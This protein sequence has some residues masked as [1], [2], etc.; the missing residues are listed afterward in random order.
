LYAS[1]SRLGVSILYDRSIF[2]WGDDWKEKLTEGIDS[3]EFTILIISESFFEGEWT[4]K[5]LSRLLRRKNPDGQKTILPLL[6]KITPEDLYKKYPSLAGLHCLTTDRSNEEIS[7]VFAKELI[8]R[9]KS[10]IAK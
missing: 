5:E 10:F 9:L 2:P 8:K 6:H 7:L 3:S 4:G 1:L